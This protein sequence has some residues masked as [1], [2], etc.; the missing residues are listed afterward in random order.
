MVGAV[1]ASTAFNTRQVQARDLADLLR[2][3]RAL[4]AAQAAQAAARAQRFDIP[5]GPLAT[6]I[7]ALR[8]AT[9]LTILLPDETFGA[10]YSRGVSGVLTVERALEEALAGTTLSFRFTPPDAVVIE[11]RAETEHVDVTGRASLAVASP[12]FT[13]PLRDTPQS[14]DVVTSEV[15]ADQ[16]ATTL[17]DAVRNVAGISLAA[18]EGGAQGDNL[19][20]R[21]FTA[22]NDIFIDGMRDFGSYYRDPFNQEQVQVLKGPSSVAFGRGTTGGVLNQATKVP[23]LE[24]FVKGTANLGTDLTERAT[25]DVNEPLPELG[26]GAAFRLNVMATRANVAGRD[27]A[28]NR[29]YGIAPSLSLGLGAATRATFTLL[30]Q[31]ENDVPDYGIPWLLDAPAPVPRSNYYG[32]ANTNFL[33][34]RADGVRQRERHRSPALRQLRPPRADHRGAHADEPDARH[35]ARHDQRRPQRDYGRQHRDLPA[36][37]VRRDEPVPYRRRPSHAR[38]RSRALARDLGADPHDVRGR[39]Q[40]EPPVA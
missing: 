24:S 37:P 4:Q 28:E 20:I 6:V 3:S 26:A 17:R 27:V 39:A 31:A 40:H 16:G 21:G 8:Q 36:E 1:V 30:H 38:R 15:L 5:P 34:T 11:F 29:R 35:A 33:D 18:G 9:G 2:G 12:K 13:E 19:T 10:I 23:V 14:I 22:R 7:V 32:F 25:L